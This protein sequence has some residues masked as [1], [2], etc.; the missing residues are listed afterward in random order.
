[1]KSN[2]IAGNGAALSPRKGKSVGSSIKHGGQSLPDV[3]AVGRG[4]FSCPPVPAISHRGRAGV[5]RDV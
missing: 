5:R 3:A 2:R 1:M 4:G